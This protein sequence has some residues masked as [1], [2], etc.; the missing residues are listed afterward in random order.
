MRYGSSLPFGK[1]PVGCKWMYTVKKKSDGSI[2]RL[3]ARLVTKGCTQTHEIDY[4][5]TFALVAKMNSVRTIISCA[6]NF[7][8]NLHQLDV[9]NAFLHGDL[10]EEV[11]ME[12]PPGITLS[13]SSGKVYN[14]RKNFVCVEAVP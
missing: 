10:K 6:T 5:E 9:K 2:E 13:A 12:V 8:W 4:Q 11:Y 7:G 1:K 14:L 3:K